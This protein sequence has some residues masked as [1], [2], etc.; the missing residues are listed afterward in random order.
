MAPLVPLFFNLLFVPT[1]VLMMLGLELRTIF[2]TTKLPVYF[3]LSL[4]SMRFPSLNHDNMVSVEFD[5]FGFSV[6]DFATANIV[7]RSNSMG[8]LYPF[9]S[10]HGAPVSSSTSSAFS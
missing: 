6:K 9:Q 1:I 5:P 8:D 2:K 3:T 4:N 10:T 7:L